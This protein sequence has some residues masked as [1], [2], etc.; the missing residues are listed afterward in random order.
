MPRLSP[1]FFRL[2]SIE[3]KLDHLFLVRPLASVF[4]TLAPYFREQDSLLQL[5]LA[6][7]V[8]IPVWRTDAHVKTN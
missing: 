2:E 6:N 8:K 7:N 4:A 1:S 5:E 3:L